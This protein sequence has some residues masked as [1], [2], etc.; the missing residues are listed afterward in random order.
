MSEFKCHLWPSEESLLL[1]DQETLLE[2]L[3][4]AGYPIKSSCG[5]CATC[6][7]CIVVVKGGEDHL[8]P[9]SFEELKLLGNVFH[10]TKERL[11][12]QTRIKGE[13]SLDISAHL[14]GKSQVVSKGTKTILKKKEL[15]EDSDSKSQEQVKDNSQKSWYRHW[16]KE[17]DGSRVP[18]KG[19]NRR[20]KAFKFNQDNEK[21]E[22]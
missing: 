22:N 9:P 1:N 8:T 19:G 3:K 2:Q 12:C 18:K 11:A 10:I 17:G 15:Q 6:S 7:D 14:K 21:K 13:V 20:P 4:K 5:G 16:E